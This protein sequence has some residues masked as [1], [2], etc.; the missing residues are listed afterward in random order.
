[1]NTFKPIRKT[2]VNEHG[3]FINSTIFPRICVRTYLDSNGKTYSEMLD[4]EKSLS[5][6]PDFPTKA[7]RTFYKIYVIWVI[8]MLMPYMLL[9]HSHNYLVYL[10]LFITMLNADHIFKSIYIIYKYKF[11]NIGKYYAAKNMVISAYNALHRIPTID[12]VKE[13]SIFEKY[14]PYESLLKHSLTYFLE[15]CI[16]CFI[17]LWNY[18]FVPIGLII[19]FIVLCLFNNC[20][21]LKYLQFFITSKPSDEI[22]FFA[23]KALENLIFSEKL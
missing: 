22:I 9:V 10:L 5:I 6:Y 13:F 2:R 17:G 3:I 18:L 11:K 12:E 14:C 19:L 23:I 16:V 8:S 7:I 1:M 15:I 20:R 4:W 21:Y